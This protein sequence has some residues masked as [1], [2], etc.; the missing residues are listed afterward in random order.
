MDWDSVYPVAKDV[1]L[2]DMVP[3][4]E[5][6]EAAVAFNQ[7]Y[8]AFLDVLTQAYNGKPQLIEAAVPMMFTLRNRLNELIRNPLPDRREHA[9]PT[10]ELYG[11]TK[12]GSLS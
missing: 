6:H 2:K 10:F 5:L 1:K 4:S 3:G 8:A 9:G 12:A 7:E 11:P